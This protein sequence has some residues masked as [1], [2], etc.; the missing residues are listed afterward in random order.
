MKKFIF[1]FCL[2]AACSGADPE[3]QLSEN[4]ILIQNINIINVADG[5]I[6]ESKHILIDSGRIVQISNETIA[7]PENNKSIDG[8]GK[9]IMP[10]LAEMHAHIPPEPT[11]KE[12]IDNILFLY[13]SNGITTIRGM[14]GH[15]Y[16]LKLRE[17]AKNNEILSPRIFTSSPSL[18][19]NTVKTL[20]EAKEK[21]IKYKA[22]GYDFLKI[23]PGIKLDVFEQIVETANEV[24]I[25]YAGHV[26]VEVGIRRALKS[27]YASVDHV[28]GYLEGLVPESADVEAN[29]NGFF[30]YNF[31]NLADTTMIDELIQMT[32]DNNVW[33]VPTQSLFER[34]FSPDDP[35]IYAQADEM[36]YMPKSTVEKWVTS[37]TNLI[38]NDN[39]NAAQWG[40][41]IEIRRQLIY[42][43]N[44]SKPGL[45][46]G[47]DAPQVFNVP[48]FSIHHEMQ[49]MIDAGLT[50]LEAIQIG[51]I[52]PAKYFNHEGEF[53]EV[54]G[55]ASAD[56]I[57]LNAN[58]L[59][60][61]SNLK[62]IEG[63]MV[64]G[65]WISKKEIDLKLTKIAEYFSDK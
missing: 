55:G 19:G 60:D 14:L 32:R 18:N 41:F 47:S 20:E 25:P 57:I 9:Y 51:T 16:H 5:S 38:G 28:D 37:K 44:K 56:L 46:L 29:K 65:Q 53:G 4:A 15:P 39:Y 52:N 45:I 11:G 6:A 58:P 43:L 49:G 12:H 48:G 31:T 35:G 3:D 36:K 34:W 13:L 2:F 30:G 21:I 64:R 62:T 8:T 1:I 7:F 24:G 23:H 63:V 22:D 26:P 61:I 59:L 10:G 27:H 54:I 50:P 33:V 42:K 17:Q 40:K